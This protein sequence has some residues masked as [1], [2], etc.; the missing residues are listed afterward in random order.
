M[1][2]RKGCTFQTEYSARMLY[3]SGHTVTVWP[4]LP[5]EIERLSKTRTQKNLPNMLIPDGIVF[6][7]DLEKVCETKLLLFA[8]PS[9]FVR[10]TAKKVAPSVNDQQI[11][12]DVAKGIEPDTLLTMSQVISTEIP[13]I[14]VVALSGPTHAEEVSRDLPTTIVAAHENIAIAEC[15]QEIFTNPVMR[16]Y[17]NTDVKGVELCG[18]LKNIIALAAGISAG[19]GYGDNTK[20][21]LITR[22]LAEI[23]RLVV[24][25]GCLPETFSGLAG[26]GDLIVTATSKRSRNNRCGYLIGQGYELSEAVNAVG[27][28]VEGINALPAA[29]ALSEK[30]EVEMPIVAAVD[31]IINRRVDPKNAVR[32]LM[33]RDSKTEL[34]KPVLDL[35]YESALIKNAVM[36]VKGDQSMKRVITYGTFDLLHY[37]H[38]NLLRRAKALGDY[39]I[40][41]ISSD[42]FNWNEKHK[43]CYFTYEQRKA[44]VEA[45][46][47]VDLVIPEESW[48][49][50]R[51]DMHEYH[52]DTFVMG[53]DWKGK[54]D[55]LK[56]EGV[57]VVYLPRTPE[58]SSSQIKKDLYDANAVDGESKTSHDEIN[59]DPGK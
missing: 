20:A 28:V 34:P 2:Y 40:V 25:M 16:V 14:P 26:M 22:G 42:E 43:K 47:Y 7:T 32:E 27:M 5:E 11:I 38:I 41:V 37:G 17:T 30:Y 44:L 18:A 9:V 24:K 58:I 50:K 10:S 56:E 8:V 4:A 39:L 46:R 21:A 57:E 3:N 54:F 31:A 55:F 53:D 13:N 45:I 19:L 49:Q 29:I 36:R 35:N 23:E 59:T 48:S 52:I 1:K 33:G 12:V 15:I 6:T 51:T